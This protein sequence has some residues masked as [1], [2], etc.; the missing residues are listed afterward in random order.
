MELLEVYSTAVTEAILP[1]GIEPFFSGNFSESLGN[2]L[3][4][5]LEPDD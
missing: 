3:L 2:R 5:A 1:P 4:G